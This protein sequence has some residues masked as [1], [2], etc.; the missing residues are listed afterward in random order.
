LY[1]Q[2]IEI[3]D[4][5]VFEEA[6][7][8]LQYPG[9][10]EKGRLHSPNINL[11]LGNN[12]AGKTTVLKALALATLAPVIDKS[13]FLPY[14]LV[15]HQREKASITVQV[16]LHPQD[17]GKNTSDVPEQSL[18]AEIVRQ[19]DLE[20]LSSDATSMPGPWAGM[21]DNSSPAFIV[22]GYGATRRCRTRGAT[23]PTSRRNGASCATSG[24]PAC[25]SPTS[26]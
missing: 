4:L 23:T 20:I 5:R 21:F 12:G 26:R 9:R 24:W 19:G 1:V 14:H 2:E 16:L 13:G 6:S 7:L 22:V 10:L 25:S 18:K 8:A 11:L 15:R 17:L 3:H